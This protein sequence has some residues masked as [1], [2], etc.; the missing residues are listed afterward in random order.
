MYVYWQRALLILKQVVYIP[1]YIYTYI[2]IYIY[3]YIHTCIHTCLHELSLRRYAHTSHAQICKHT[4]NLYSMTLSGDECV[5]TLIY[6]QPLDS[7]WDAAVRE[8][9]REYI[10]CLHLHAT[11]LRVCVYVCVFVCVL[12]IRVYVFYMKS[13]RECVCVR[14]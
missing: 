2:H 3:T 6:D 11:K 1:V 12:C 14:M 10:Y 4:D 8:L 13:V 9:D 7:E 5:V